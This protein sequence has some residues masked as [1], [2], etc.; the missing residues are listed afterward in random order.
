MPAIHM[1][2]HTAKTASHAA[3]FL[4]AGSLDGPLIIF[5][6]GWPTLI[7]MAGKSSRW[8]LTS[9]S[10]LREGMGHDKRLNRSSTT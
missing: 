10:V 3:F 5:V 7:A 1:T 9:T 8:R 6:H 4:A 2:E